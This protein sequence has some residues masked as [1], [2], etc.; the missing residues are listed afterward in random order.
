L[1]NCPYEKPH[2]DTSVV[3]YLF[4]MALRGFEG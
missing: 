4:N 3:G 2:H 1:G